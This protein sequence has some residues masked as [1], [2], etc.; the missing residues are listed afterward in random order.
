VVY[1]TTL[2]RFLDDANAVMVF[3][4]TVAKQVK[5]LEPE[6]VHIVNVTDVAAVSEEIVSSS[7]ART[8]SAVATTALTLPLDVPATATDGSLL[9]EYMLVFIAQRVVV[10][11]SNVGTAY[12]L[13]VTRLQRAVRT[14]EFT[15][16]LRTLAVVHEAPAFLNTTTE[17][18]KLFIDTHYSTIV[19][20][21]AIP[22]SQPSSVPSGQP[23]SQ[24][25]MQPSLQPT[26]EPTSQPSVQPSGQPTAAPTLTIETQWYNALEALFTN[27]VNQYQPVRATYFALDVSGAALYGSCASWNLF[28]R[29]TL[30]TTDKA[31]VINHL[32][33][34]VQATEPYND[35][36]VFVCADLAAVQSVVAALVAPQLSKRGNYTVRTLCGGVAWVVHE[37]FIDRRSTS[38][39]LCVDCDT[40]CSQYDCTTDT[41]S[42][43]LSPCTKEPTC[44]Y[45]KGSLQVL[46]AYSTPSAGTGFVAVMTWYSTVWAALILAVLGYNQLVLWDKD[47]MHFRNA[48]KLDLFAKE[49]KAG[50]KI[51]AVVPGTPSTPPV[52]GSINDAAQGICETIAAVSRVTRLMSTILDRLMIAA[53]KNL[54]LN[55]DR[56][57]PIMQTFWH[58]LLSYNHYLAPYTSAT[59][60]E[61]LLHALNV[62][63][64]VSWLFFC[65]ALCL[66]LNY[67]EDDDSCYFKTTAQECGQRVTPFDSSQEYCTWVGPQGAVEA[68][69]EGGQPVHQTQCVWQMPT[70]TVLTALH[71]CIV[72]VVA[73]MAPKLLY[74]NFLLEAVLFAPASDM[75][76]AFSSKKQMQ[77]DLMGLKKRVQKSAKSAG[78]SPRRLE[79]S[80]YATP[81]KGGNKVAP[82]PVIVSGSTPAE[83]ADALFQTFIMHFAKYRERVGTSGPAF[84]QF[85]DEWVAANPFVYNSSGTLKELRRDVFLRGVSGGYTAKLK[86]MEELA[87]V[88]RSA[89]D[90]APRFERLEASEDGDQFS[91]RLMAL[92]FADLLGKDSIQC[93]LV[94][95][96][97]R[98]LLQDSAPFRDVRNW[99]KFCVI[100]F[101][102]VTCICLVY[103]SIALL[104]HFSARRQWYWVITAALAVAVDMVL[105]EGVEA[106]WFQ[107]ALPLCVVDVL[108]ALKQTFCTVTARYSRTVRTQPQRVTMIRASGIATADAALVVDDATSAAILHRNFNMPHYQFLSTNLAQRFPR[109]VASRIVLSYESAYPRT[110]TGQRWPGSRMS[111]YCSGLG[112]DSVGYVLF[113]HPAMRF[114]VLCPRFLQQVLIAG[115][116]SLVIWLLSLAVRR[117]VEGIYIGVYAVVA[118]TGFIA[119]AAMSYRVSWEGDVE[120]F[121][122]GVQGLLPE[123]DADGAAVSPRDVEKGPGSPMKRFALRARQLV[124]DTGR[125]WHDSALAALSPQDSPRQ[126]QD[127]ASPL[128][129]APRSMSRPSP[130]RVR[131]TIKVAP[132]NISRNDM[133]ED[134]PVEQQW[135]SAQMGRRD[136]ESKLA[137]PEKSVSHSVARGSEIKWASVAN[138]SAASLS[139][140]AATGRGDLAIYDLSSSSSEGSHGDSDNEDARQPSPV[141]TVTRSKA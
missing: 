66:W 20:H 48:P 141:E 40:P 86:V 78:R 60:R 103:G 121:A 108:A 44:P 80:F 49:I 138:A 118:V 42:A 36:V 76:A 38:R 125:Q 1:R 128:H 43:V 112:V 114:A 97:L 124:I 45:L 102:L 100:L 22:T 101:M 90:T 35:P 50:K 89:Q 135:R 30:V 17:I 26:S 3:K 23:S 14:G 95:A 94:R 2:R 93:R 52:V 4:T 54:S 109:H 46:T 131:T 139:A 28:T 87:A 8:R 25:T 79:A 51:A 115:S 39:G 33:Y 57:L 120:R 82:L 32:E 16:N 69:E 55:G 81:G 140:A 83:E 134:V 130:L 136:G 71:I 96:M 41:G 53:G 61:R 75:S 47:W 15:M 122:A 119:L 123:E 21:S 113:S 74:T 92:F 133:Q 85:R 105:V 111:Y 88:R 27:T 9:I 34:V 11:S 68:A 127:D 7:A 117:A 126:E 19:T 64:R 31:R 37:C 77:K 10:A 72:T 29:R 18:K 12:N 91:V 56:N 24:P 5:G 63:T 58:R 6:D 59:Q 70:C 107:W 84:E 73:A 65:V 132:L 106:L 129:A 67:P 104:E 13:T 110:I 62:L 99:V 98:D 116:I 137:T